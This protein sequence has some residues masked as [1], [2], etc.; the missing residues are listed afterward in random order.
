LELF[1]LEADAEFDAVK[2]AWRRL[3]KENHPDVKPGDAEAAKR[4]QAGQ[5][6]YDVLRVAEEN[7]QWRPA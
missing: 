5:A 4:F 3:A 6:A 1:E 7:R 2:Q